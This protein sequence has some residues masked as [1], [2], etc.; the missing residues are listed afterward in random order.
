M[1]AIKKML[2]QSFSKGCTKV[3]TKLQKFN[4]DQRGAGDAMGW[5]MGIFFALLLL[6]IVFNLFKDQLP[7]FITEKIFGKMNGLN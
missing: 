2:K 3:Y 4:R 7:T 6:I 5:A 1:K